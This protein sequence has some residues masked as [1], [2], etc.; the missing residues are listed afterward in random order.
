MPDFAHEKQ[1]KKDAFETFVR[2]AIIIIAA[3]S[4]LAAIKC[5]LGSSPDVRI[6]A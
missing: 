5:I 2:I 4:I 6:S 3:G 1:I